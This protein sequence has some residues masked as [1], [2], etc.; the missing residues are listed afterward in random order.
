[1]GRGSL[2]SAQCVPTKEFDLFWG[3]KIVFLAWNTKY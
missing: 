2:N 1:V 3:T